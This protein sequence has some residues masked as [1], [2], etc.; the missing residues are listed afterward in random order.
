MSA[1]RK[2]RIPEEASGKYHKDTFDKISDKKREKIIKISTVEFAEKGFNGANVN[3]IANKAGISIG[4]MYNY[5]SSKEHLFL[6]IV[7]E[8]YKL[9]EEA[10]AGADLANG[11]I[12]QKLETI[13]R[14]AQRHSRSHPQFVQLYQD[15]TTESLA[16]LSARLSRKIENI[17]A[18]FYR[19]YLMEA[20]A[21]G[22]VDPAIDVRVASYC[23]DNIIVLM[24][25]SYTSEYYKERLL[26]FIGE[27][28]LEDDERVIKGMV[29]FIRRA[30]GVRK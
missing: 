24:Q 15:I 9:L 16:H 17:S 29:D 26:T 3:V 13:I 5:F 25:F 1:A 8:G 7:D 2:R 11:D 4:S 28:A 12:F 6:T 19:N 21:Q 14:V 22:L 30:I 23:I 10:F 20:K 18:V 27:D